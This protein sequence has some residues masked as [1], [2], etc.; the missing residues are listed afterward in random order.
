M[1]KKVILSKILIDL[2]DNYKGLD[3]HF[4]DFSNKTKIGNIKNYNNK[5]IANNIDS[6]NKFI[7]NMDNSKSNNKKK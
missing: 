4:N 7:S 1:R 3:E 5:I 6:F 2:I